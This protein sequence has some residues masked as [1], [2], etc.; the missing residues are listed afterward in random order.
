MAEIERCVQ[1]TMSML[2]LNAKFNF[3]LSKHLLLNSIDKSSDV[4]LISILCH[5]IHNCHSFPCC[6]SDKGKAVDHVM[7]PLFTYPMGYVSCV[8]YL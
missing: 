3:G 7:V 8:N 6:C 2:W 1:C 4:N 5:F